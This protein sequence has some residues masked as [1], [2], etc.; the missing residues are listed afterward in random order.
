MVYSRRTR[1]PQPTIL[2]KPRISRERTIGKDVE[3]VNR[4][5]N[6]GRKQEYDLDIPITLRKWIRSCTK[7]PIS[8]FLGYSKLSPQFRAFTVNVDNVIIPKNI[9]NA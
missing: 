6:R 8:N 2:S 7:H 5:D 9:Y 1:D 4:E 3:D